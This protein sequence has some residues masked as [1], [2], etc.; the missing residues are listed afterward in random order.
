MSRLNS[1]VDRAKRK[2]LMIKLMGLALEIAPP[3]VIEKNEIDRGVMVLH[4]CI[5]E[6]EKDMGLT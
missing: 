6:E 2:G 5:A 3:L 1:L 4:E